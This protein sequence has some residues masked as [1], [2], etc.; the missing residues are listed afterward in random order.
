MSVP[1]LPDS[2]CKANCACPKKETRLSREESEMLAQQRQQR[3]AMRQ[4]NGDDAAPKSLLSSSNGKG[5][6]GASCTC[7]LQSLFQSVTGRRGL[8]VSVRFR[9]AVFKRGRYEMRTFRAIRPMIDLPCDLRTP[10]APDVPPNVNWCLQMSSKQ[11]S[12][13]THQH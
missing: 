4:K 3:T 5:S 7:E 8:K 11:M 10:P 2:V 13:A 6:D 9:R 12:P 1:F